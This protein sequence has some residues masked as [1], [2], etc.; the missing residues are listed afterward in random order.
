MKLATQYKGKYEQLVKY[1]QLGLDSWVKAG[2]VIKNL[3]DQDGHSV[4]D[5]SEATG[6][7]VPVVGKLESLGRKLILPQLLIATWPAASLIPQLSYSQQEKVVEDGVD[8]LLENGDTL[9]VKA[10]NMTY[11]QAKQVLGGG[12]IRSLPAQKA[13]LEDEKRKAVTSIKKQ[14]TATYQVKGGRVFI[15]TPCQL[16]QKDLLRMLQELNA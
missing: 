6:I 3:I 4:A 1:I 7:P 10:E 8:L 2:E 16:T 11:H 14:A 15:A 9:K 12:S 5:I 13:W